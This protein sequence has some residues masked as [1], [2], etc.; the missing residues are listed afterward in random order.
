MLLLAQ[1][2]AGEGRIAGLVV[3]SSRGKAPV[4]SAD[5]YLQLRIDGEFYPVART[6]AGR[7]GRFLF[8][9]LPLE[10]GLVYL[11]GA[12]QDGIHYPGP[13]IRLTEDRP[14]ADVV[15]TVQDV[16]TEP[17]PLLIRDWSIV[18]EPQPGALRVTETL[19]IENPEP[20]TY[21]GQIPDGG[22]EPVTLRLGIPSD[23][24]RVTFSKEFYGRQFALIDGKLVTT[25][26]WTPGQRELQFSYVV[27]NERSSRT[28]TRPVDLPCE[29]VR[30][31]VCKADG[32]GLSCNLG[33]A[34]PGGDGTVTFESN[35]H[36][37]PAGYTIRVELS[38]IQVSMMVY[39][40]WVILA[41]LVLVIAVSCLRMT[42]R[43]RANDQDERTRG[44]HQRRM[45]AKARA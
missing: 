20:R 9:G 2:P 16:I 39:A 43:R 14:S 24:E 42:R 6:S 41:L 33:A 21:V 36:L 22:A 10:K 4:E 45:K 7:D 18:L 29:H 44:P 25:L 1:G 19:S 15:V 40:R 23:F 34:S 30:L 32:D 3:N 13:R 11:P 12:A 17:D 5:V 37:L 35:G 28:W 38:R 26:P 27:R 31:I 8:E